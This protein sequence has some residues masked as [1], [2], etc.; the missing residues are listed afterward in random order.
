MVSFVNIHATVVFLKL[1]LQMQEKQ[2][3]TNAHNYMSECALDEQELTFAKVIIEVLPVKV[4]F[5]LG[6]NCQK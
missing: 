3:M 2:L 5:D 1:I 6:S 4:I